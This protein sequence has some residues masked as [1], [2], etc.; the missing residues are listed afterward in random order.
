MSED[1]YDITTLLHELAEVLGYKVE[2]KLESFPTDKEF[3]DKTIEELIMEIKTLQTKENSRKAKIRDLIQQIETFAKQEGVRFPML[4]TVPEV[5]EAKKR[6][7]CTK[8]LLVKV[9][10]KFGLKPVR[11]L[12]QNLY[13]DLSEE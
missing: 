2:E 9:L 6:N 5:T 8:A 4:Y 3:E 10:K 13:V 11:T 12:Q 7:L 1:E